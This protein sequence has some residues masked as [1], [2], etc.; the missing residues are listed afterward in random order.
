M[1]HQKLAEA[2]LGAPR[3]WFRA[4]GHASGISHCDPEPGARP[5]SAAAL[6]PRGDAGGFHDFPLADLLRRG[7]AALRF[8]AGA[9]VRKEPG[10]FHARRSKFRIKL[11]R[12]STLAVI[13]SAMLC[14]AGA[15]SFSTNP[16]ADALVTTGP[17]GALSA[18]NY[19]GAGGLA[20]AASGLPKGAF[21]SVLQFDLSGARNSF[22]AQFG[23]GQWTIQSVTLQLT[24]ANN[25]NP[26]FFNATTAGQFSISLLK[27]NSWVEGTGT[28]SAPAA[29]GISYRPL[30]AVADA[31]SEGDGRPSFD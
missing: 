15:S 3:A 16:F 17:G 28:P 9:Q 21:Q 8:M 13:F 30:R 19:G 22:D 11:S 1:Q 25:N 5:S 14:A 27:N 23:A 29:N 2:V 12:A 24:A 7:T 26:G 4:S 10:V 31:D 6:A 18:N 20:I